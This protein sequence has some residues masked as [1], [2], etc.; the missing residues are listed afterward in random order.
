MKFLITVACLFIVSYSWSDDTEIY[1][2]LGVNNNNP[3]TRV[4]SNVL[5]VI[6]TSGS[7]GEPANS[8]NQQRPAYDAN[9]NYTGSYNTDEF[10]H[11]LNANVDDGHQMSAFFNSS[12][13]DNWSDC[14]ETISTLNSN[15]VKTGKYR[16]AKYKG[17]G[18]FK[19]WD[20]LRNGADSPVRCTLYSG[21]SYTL[22]SGNYMNYY[23]HGN[24]NA[25]LTRL[26][27]VKNVVTEVTNSLSN[28]NVG[29]MRFDR[30]SDGGFIDVPVSDINT[31]RDLIQSTINAYS[32][33]GGTPIEETYY[34][35]VR[36]YRGETWMFGNDSS[37]SI[38]TADSRL[39]NDPTRYNSP[40]THT[41]Q[42]NHIILLTDGAPTNDYAAND[43]I[44]GL[45]A[46]STLPSGLS[47]S[48][49]GNGACMEEL[50]Y[51]SLNSDHSDSLDGDQEIITYTIAGF[52][53][54]TE[55]EKNRLENVAYWGGGDYFSANNT[56]ELTAALNSIFL[57]I[58]ATDSTFTAPAVSVNAFNA[59]EHRDEL[60]Y[61][62]FRPSNTVK[63]T[64]NVKRYKLDDDGTVLDK[65]DQPAISEATGFF[66]DDVFDIWNETSSADGKNVGLGGM[67]NRFTTP[68]ARNIYTNTTD[69]D[70]VSLTASDGA[71]KASFGMSTD[72]D[73]AYQEVLN[74]TIGIDVDD[75]DNDDNLT[76]SR[77]QIGDPLHSEP[78][79][80]TYGGTEENP[81]S[82][83]FFGTNE[84]YIHAVDTITGE[85]QF[86]F[87]PRDF[88]DKQEA[89]FTNVQAAADKPYGM[90]GLITSWFYDKNRNNL[91]INPATNQLEEGEHIYIYAGMRRGGRGYYALDVTDRSS[92]EMLFKIEGGV[93][94]GFEKLGQT[95]SKMVI[96]KIKINGNVREVLFFSGGY[97]ENQDDTSETTVRT[98][99]DV[100]NA[101]YMVDAT[102]GTLLA[103]VSNESGG[104]PF[105]IEGMDN[106]I[107]A[108]PA[109]IDING[110][111]L[112]DYLFAVDTGGRVFRIDFPG[113][114]LEYADG[115]MIADL[116]DG[117]AT[118][119]R[120]FY[121]KPNVA[122]VKDKQYGDYLTIAVGS[123][124]RAHPILTD[125]VENR[126]Y[127]IKDFNP[128]S[129]PSSVTVKTE[130]DEN[131]TTLEENENA[132]PNKLYNATALMKEGASAYNSSMQRMM[133]NGGGWY[134]TF[135]TT[136]EKVLA[137]ST[138]F[139][140]AVIFTTFSPTGNV[141]NACGAD[142]GSS[143]TYVL[144]QKNAMAVIDLD[145]DGDVDE[146]D[147]SKSLAHS[148]IAP[149]PVV[150]YRS[151]GGKTIAIGTETIDDK[152]FST[153]NYDPTCAETNSCQE[154]P[155]CQGANCDVTPTY[156]RQNKK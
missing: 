107:P 121:N 39:A 17:N 114:A 125:H 24:A 7:M 145:G 85:E 6:D 113:G 99:D 65:N 155:K 32:D 81:D 116:N 136:G 103:W 58:I 27:V 84:G 41:C 68:S 10:Y 87:L 60:F 12:S 76:E 62:L 127:V 143:T 134:V 90:D 149:R 132:N 35:A 94:P 11:D 70:L 109:V 40:I 50:A 13:G 110:D 28:I 100:G 146:N 128:Y 102:D 129:M 66:N 53:G 30:W 142:T 154:P 34:E 80:I 29:L 89:L 51:W 8:L 73:E 14:N 106:S 151:G 86:A 83:L 91:I 78:I 104:S 92:P 61:A 48:C 63:W 123:G 147:S 71:S 115:G 44:R 4:N 25:N 108:S 18:D 135:D 5:F 150:I 56:D 112:V 2:T 52:D 46:G 153:D 36:Y 72:T 23:H 31:S 139:S 64:G 141:S 45:V 138:T 15:G 75:F 67:A 119:N 98:S 21:S 19:S 96:S 69:G 101:I 152:R 49:S 16:Q 95:W 77:Q 126:F 118:G 42:K 140:G 57:E 111:G 124:H 120:R 1:G 122:L 55:S 144:D 93:T 156:W 26:D 137:E 97:D 117:T 59:S 22:Y 74:W 148:G 54:L 133:L 88:H 131:K 9:T 3:N 105:V 37:P 79:V 47:T 43:D 82:T 130:E 20:N 33:D 38:S